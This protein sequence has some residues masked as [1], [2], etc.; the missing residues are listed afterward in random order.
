M[1][2]TSE[3]GWQEAAFVR[4]GAGV[5]V[6]PCHQD[7]ISMFLVLFTF[8][9]SPVIRSSYPAPTV[10]FCGEQ[11]DW[12]WGWGGCRGS[13]AEE[14][15]VGEGEAGCGPTCRALGFMEGRNV[16]R[17]KAGREGGGLWWKRMVLCE[18]RLHLVHAPE[19][20]S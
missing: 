6:F 18:G 17:A 12:W 11:A 3:R 7:C 1:S 4:A 5:G 10:F 2:R 15:R 14:D 13:H 16:A 9:L 19:R 8:L 20:Q